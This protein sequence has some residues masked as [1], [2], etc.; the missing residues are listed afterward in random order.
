MSVSFAGFYRVCQ[1]T[2]RIRNWDSALAICF[3]LYNV[4]I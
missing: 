1:G 4:L 3:G 2:P